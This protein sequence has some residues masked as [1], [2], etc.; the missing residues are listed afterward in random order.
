MALIP[1]EGLGAPSQKTSLLGGVAQ[2]L[3]NPRPSPRL[4]DV[5][6]FVRPKSQ[7]QIHRDS[8]L[9]QHLQTDY[10]FSMIETVV[11]NFSLPA[12]DSLVHLQTCIRVSALLFLPRFIKFRT[13]FSDELKNYTKKILHSLPTQKFPES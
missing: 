8:K 11:D 7:H 6:L 5:G 4:A 2:I 13:I 9:L 1:L 12:V 3:I 10:E